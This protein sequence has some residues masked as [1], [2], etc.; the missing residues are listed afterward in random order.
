MALYIYIYKRLETGD[1]RLIN[2]LSN[3]K[4]YTYSIFLINC[5]KLD[6]FPQFLGLHFVQL[7]F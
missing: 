3:Q 1:S 7:L 6:I 5:K 4:Q 2:D